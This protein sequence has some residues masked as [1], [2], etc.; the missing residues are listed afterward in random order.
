M[1]G[2]EQWKIPVE[3]WSYHIEGHKLV[4]NIKY[5]LWEHINTI[6][7]MEYWKKGRESTQGGKSWLGINGEGNDDRML[8]ISKNGLVNLQRW[9]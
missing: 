5:Q 3:P 4:K 9:Y 8:Y 6:P 1:T 2:S 7:I